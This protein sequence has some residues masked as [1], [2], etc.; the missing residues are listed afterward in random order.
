MWDQC[1]GN[2]HNQSSPVTIR[3]HLRLDALITT[4]YEDLS[5]LTTK[6]RHWVCRPRE[7]IFM[8]TMEYKHQWLKSVHLARAHYNRHHHTL[9][10]AQQNLMWATFG[11]PLSGFAIPCALPPFH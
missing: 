5:T 8:E 4:E 6:D 11:H 9:T 7:A 10:Q 3:K 2:I 1:N